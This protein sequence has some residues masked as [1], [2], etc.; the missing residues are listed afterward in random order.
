M[1]KS[2]ILAIT[3]FASFAAAGQMQSLGPK[4]TFR[5]AKLSSKEVQ[6]I[7]KLVEASAYD[8]ADDW[9]TELRVR[10]V[11][12]GS[13][14]GLVLQGSNLLCGATANCQLWVFRKVGNR[15][16]SLF[17]S[18][19]APIAEGFRL[20]PGATGGIKDLTIIANSSAEAGATTRYKFDGKF[21]RAR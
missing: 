3:L 20:G 14:P 2:S 9:T 5:A 17:S 8:M 10:R 6:E 7:V 21:Y 4:D 18:D 16:L 1:K 12:L 13:S 15:W 11:D 19:Q